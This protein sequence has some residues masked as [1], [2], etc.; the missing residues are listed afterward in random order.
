MHTQRQS[1]T[2]SSMHTATPILLGPGP[3]R[4]GAL[5]GTEAASGTPLPH[6]QPR[7]SREGA[8]KNRQT[9][10]RPAVWRKWLICWT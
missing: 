5:P 9:R 2:G 8:K 10:K 1:L 4:I 7:H 3:M 6:R